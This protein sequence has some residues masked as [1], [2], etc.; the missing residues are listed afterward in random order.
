[1]KIVTKII[2][3]F[4]I[5]IIL[6][7]FLG[8]GITYIY[9]ERIEQ[10]LLKKIREKSLAEIQ[11]KD[12][13][14]SFFKNFPY[15]SIKLNDVLIIE[16]EERYPDTLLYAKEG[17]FQ[18]NIFQL[19][20]EQQEINKIV[21]YKSNLN[22][23]YDENDNTN[24]KIIKGV[25]N[26]E[27]RLGINQILFLDSKITYL[28]KRKETSIESIAH[29]LLLDIQKD[30]KTRATILG[31]ILINKLL[32]GKTDYINNKECVIDATISVLDNNI[33]IDNST[34]YIEDVECIIS[35]DIKGNNVNLDIEAQEQKIK[36]VFMHM[37]ESYKSTFKSFKADGYLS[38]KGKIIGE[39]S[40]NSNPDFEMDVT[41]NDGVFTLEESSFKL[42]GISMKAYIDNGKDNNF[43]STIIKVDDY[44]STTDKSYFN[45]SFQIKNLNKYYIS[46]DI[47]SKIDLREI[48]TF[49]ESTPF[50]NMKG[51]LSS[52]TKYSGILSF[53][54]NMR[55]HFLDAI[56][57]SSISIK[58]MEFQYM[59][60]PLVFGIQN[61]V[62]NI[63]NNKI[64]VENSS[65]TISDSDFKYQG[66]I[67]NLISYLLNESEKIVLNGNMES[68]YIRFD[69]LIQITK[70]NS[71]KTKSTTTLPDWVELYLSTQ[72]K[73][74][75]YQYF[76]AEDLDLE[77]SYSDYTLEAKELEMSTLNG[78]ITGE[79]KFFEYPNNYLKLI[80]SAHLEKINI[81]DLFT[82]FQNFG[83]EF[84]KDKH[85][86]GVGT[87]DIQLKSSWNPG[88]DFDPN[89]LELNSHLIIEK[90]ELVD[91]SPLLKLSS[92][93]SV[94][95]L[96]N[97][98]FST[99]ENT[100]K[101]SKNNINI[102]A[103]EIESSALSVFVSGTHNFDNE[104]D[105][106]IRLLLS[107]LLSRKSREKNKSFD[108]E[109]GA[110]IDDDLGR[111]TLYLRMDGT[112]VDPN[113]YFDKIRIKEK[114]KKEV[115]K[116]KEEIKKIIKEDI[117]K[118]KD[119]STVKLDKNEEDIL[120][121]WKDE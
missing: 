33:N 116:E 32:V 89:K 71:S 100:I 101:I 25:E 31:D 72:I 14:L 74:F 109:F 78:G 22:I 91:F 50:I 6:T 37:P 34:F 84:I 68:I 39:V 30:E 53:S 95:E 52:N 107:N 80:T 5:S 111:T 93:V 108:D 8:I 104:I 73:Q 120:L 44:I 102:P 47:N 66:D 43:E 76:I 15:A 82:A 35:G 19:F 13:N 67:T 46:T 97:V 106:R 45:G 38:C 115:K 59:E 83:Q 20:N 60:S 103:M 65:I 62:G 10:E 61:L 16:K 51:I 86:K 12:V 75:S 11:V 49:F 119:T 64:S 99:L 7:I 21:F 88:F 27:K 42:S 29:N 57:Q 87:A 23:K 118:Q 26:K 81:R 113:I 70:I 17:N 92:Y 105:Y 79:A 36:S 3:T 2:N 110:L 77:L 58:D 54:E 112:S 4:F 55:K 90:G 114:I 96:S 1:M 56:H 9:G 24:F 40:K 41:I 48:N 69:E 85:I 117:L 18:F 121:E 98:K 63:N 28:H 94:E